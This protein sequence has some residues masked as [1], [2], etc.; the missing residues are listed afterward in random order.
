M[1]TARNRHAPI[2]L[3]ALIISVFTLLTPVS[4]AL[5]GNI[6]AP[7][8]QKALLEYT[9]DIE[10]LASGTN[11]NYRSQKWSTRRTLVASAMLTAL[12]PSVQDPGDPG[13][14][15]R[16]SKSGDAGFKPSH[17][18]AAY[19]A[20]MEKCG[21]DMSCRM[22]IAQKMQND[23]KVKADM[24]KG[25][26]STKGSPRYQ[27]WVVE[28]TSSVTG[29]V[30]VEVK[31]EDYFKTAV[32][33]I[34]NCTETAEVAFEKLIGGS[35][36]PATIKIDAKAGTYAANIDIPSKTFLAKIDCMLQMGR[37]RSERHTTSGRKF[38]P[39]KYQQA[40]LDDIEVFRGG[41]DAAAGGR[42]LAHS[43]KVVTGDYGTLVGNVPM[44]AKITVRW[45]ITLKD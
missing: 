7:K 36:W 37:E 35:T 15:H 21:N 12:Q 41:A 20:E 9:I 32:D 33:E 11:Q 3:K 16:A 30:K 40:T 19:M 22:R 42:R 1:T 39:E 2:L 45:S 44:A 43:E 28:R 14:S 8:G 17:E 29:N 6:L 38:L 4:E 24:N 31:T 13:G 18:T 25:T 26:E 23:P 27:V 10:G 5:A 34:T